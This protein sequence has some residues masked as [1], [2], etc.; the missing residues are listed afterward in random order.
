MLGSGNH[1]AQNLA[2]GLDRSK[3]EQQGWVQFYLTS[4]YFLMIQ[5]SA[6]YNIWQVQQV[7]VKLQNPTLGTLYFV[8]TT[9]LI[10][11]LDYNASFAYIK[12]SCLPAF[13]SHVNTKAYIKSCT[14]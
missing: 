1:S 10:W 8:I 14:F 11:I 5:Q 12:V 3:T 13:S 6:L 2:L 9:P 7:K 4:Q